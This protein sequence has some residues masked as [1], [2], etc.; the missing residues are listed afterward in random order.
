MRYLLDTHTLIWHL[1]DS[2]C[3]PQSTKEI[4]DNSEGRICL[5]SVS[6][7]EIAIKIGIGK[8]KLHF[9][10]EEFLVKINNGDFNVLEI[11]D[12]HLKRFIVLPLSTTTLLI[13]C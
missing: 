13:V 9:T 4:I 6:L 12:D 5:C 10:F 11:E 3:L 1:E 2:S 8:L 7:W